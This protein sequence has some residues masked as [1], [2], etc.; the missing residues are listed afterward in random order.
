MYTKSLL[1]EELLPTNSHAILTQLYQEGDNKKEP[2]CPGFEQK[3]E[4]SLMV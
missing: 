2:M 1:Q 3:V 4:Y